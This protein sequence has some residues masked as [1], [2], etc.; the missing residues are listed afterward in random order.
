MN[1]A[2]DVAPLNDAHKVYVDAS[3]VTYK[4]LLS[5]IERT[6]VQN[7]E[8]IHAAVVPS[9]TEARAVDV[10]CTSQETNGR[11]TQT[12]SL[13]NKERSLGVVGES[14]TKQ[15]VPAISVRDLFKEHSKNGRVSYVEIDVDGFDAEVCLLNF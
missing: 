15:S 6:G 1:S 4:G 14:S 5:E 13:A 12:C 8:C 11:T 10:Y 3:S 2:L 7:T 9:T